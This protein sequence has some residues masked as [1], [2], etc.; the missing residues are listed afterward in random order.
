MTSFLRRVASYRALPDTEEQAAR[1]LLTI[2]VSQQ[3]A[4]SLSGS[5]SAP[6][7][8]YRKQQQDRDPESPASPAERS[9][10]LPLREGPPPRRTY[11]A[12][13]RHPQQL[14]AAFVAGGLLTYLCVCIMARMGTS[15]GFLGPGLPAQLATPVDR[16]SG[17]VPPAWGLSPLALG[18]QTG[19]AQA[20]PD[21]LIVAVH[22]TEVRV[23][24]LHSAPSSA[25]LSC[26]SLMSHSV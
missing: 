8:S 17:G 25:E 7:L 19:D 23:S 12:L 3:P 1:P 18:N 11:S 2:H 26:K 9:S 14:A 20:T 5:L 24:R 6:E 10:L 4:R 21:R 13:M 16:C 15:L 22:H